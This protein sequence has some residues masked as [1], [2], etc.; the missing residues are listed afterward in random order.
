MGSYTASCTGHMPLKPDLT[1]E[2]G[3]FAF[4]EFIQSL[5]GFICLNPNHADDIYRVYQS[6][7]PVL[8]L[9]QH[10]QQQDMRTHWEQ[11]LA[12]LVPSESRGL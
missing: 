5:A 8:G 10:Q 6:A 9:D 1:L 7:S 2:T 3:I 11:I 12:L 4:L